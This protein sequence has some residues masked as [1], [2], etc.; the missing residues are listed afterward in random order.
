MWTFFMFYTKFVLFLFNIKAPVCE[1]C[2]IKWFGVLP[3]NLPV[4]IIRVLCDWDEDLTLADMFV[5]C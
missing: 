1:I 2:F 3:L 5:V 4:L